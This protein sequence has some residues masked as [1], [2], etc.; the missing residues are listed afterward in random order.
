MP[1]IQGPN[2]QGPARGPRGLSPLSI[3]TFALEKEGAAQ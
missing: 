2:A 1:H 3:L